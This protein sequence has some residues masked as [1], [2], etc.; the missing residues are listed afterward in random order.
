MSQVHLADIATGGSRQPALSRA[1]QQH[2]V[3]ALVDRL[4]PRVIDQNLVRVYLAS[5]NWDVD[6]AFA[7]WNADR[8]AIINGRAAAALVDPASDEDDDDD[9]EDEKE[10]TTPAGD[11]G[12]PRAPSED[13]SETLAAMEANS[14]SKGFN[15]SIEQERRDAALALRMHVGSESLGA[16]TL[17][18]TEAILLLH[19]SGWDLGSATAGFTTLRAAR[20]RLQRYDRMRVPLPED[21]N[22]NEAIVMRRQD[23]RL[24]EF[25]NITGRPDW[26]SLRLCLEQFRWN[27]IEALQ[28]WF[29]TG[30][31]PV[32]PAKRLKID[33][34]R[35]G[36]NMQ[37]LPW[38][39]EEV[40][41][42]PNADEGWGVEPEQYTPDDAKP[43][44]SDQEEGDLK[45][46]T[47]RPFGF[48][49]SLGSGSRDT[50]KKGCPNPTKFLVESIVKGRY[51][52]NRYLREGGLRWPEIEAAGGDRA[53]PSLPTF[54]WNNREHL[55]WLN[56]WN[57]QALVRATGTHVRAR[58]QTWSQEEIDF[59]IQLTE[60]L[61]QE[62]KREYPGLFKDDQL[63]PLLVSEKKK[64]EWVKRMSEKFTGTH[65]DTS[66]NPRKDRK[67]AAIMMQRGRVK[68]LV[69]RYKVAPDKVW[70]ARREKKEAKVAPKTGDKRKRSDRSPNQE[71]QEPTEETA[72]LEE[73]E[74][75][76]TLATAETDNADVGVQ[77]EDDAANDADDEGDVED[78]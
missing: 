51:W 5:V 9:D 49:I 14:I 47:D 45:V 54:D 40:C 21:V 74:F 46:K 76:T 2:A 11:A 38:P 7:Q 17:S 73:D 20:L 35:I 55:E 68:V 52:W 63:L 70:F 44:T 16:I 69:D 13:P 28:F 41:Q 34:I 6:R 72:D 27:L 75:E 58:S 43:P 57:R 15:A 22:R 77:E 78:G 33:G 8:D 56:N 26:Y 30:I 1:Q 18:P 67:P 66:G 32:R 59:L 25:I 36:L 53:D 23:E 65:Q 31:R 4:R 39:T 12:V 10:D 50:V 42:A 48:L 29:L 24:A 60:E 71:E 64:K 3:T 61:Y 62:A 37:L 19:L